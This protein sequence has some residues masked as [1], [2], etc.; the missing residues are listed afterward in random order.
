M[1]PLAGTAW[2]APG[3]VEGFAT[4]PPNPVLMAYAARVLADVPGGTA[5]DI[6]CG[7]GRNGVPLAALGWRV[8]G[9]DLSA[10]MLAAASSRAAS[11]PA[12]LRFAVAMAPMEHLPVASRRAHF[13]VAHGIWNLAPRDALFRR[14]V[15]EA[16]R[17]A[18]PGAALF[19]FTFSRHTLAPDASPVSGETYTFTQ[20]SGSPLCFVTEAQLIDELRDA[21]FERDLSVPLTEYNRPAPGLLRGTGGPVI[22]EAAFRYTRSSAR[23]SGSPVPAVISQVGRT[24]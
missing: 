12:P 1:D 6:G 7:A 23:P 10:P 21:G 14:A 17:I 11:A 15:Q 22:Y 3:T 2:S 8:L 19:V 13:I 16:A 20:F 9:L 4:S 18:A 5:V 24:A